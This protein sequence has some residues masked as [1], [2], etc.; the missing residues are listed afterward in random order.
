MDRT[1]VSLSALSPNLA[2]SLDLLADIVRNPAFDPAEVERLRAQQLAQIA[3]EMTQPQGLAL[4]TLPAAL[5]GPSHPYG[6]PFTG[7]G[8]PKAVETVSRDALVAFHDAWLRPDNA[9]IFVVSD[10]P[11]AEVQALVERSFGDWAAPAAPKGTKNLAAATPAPKPRI[12]LV[13]RPQSPQSVILGGLL[14]PYT[15]PQPIEPLIV[16]NDVLGGSFLS[17]I[18]MDLRETKGWSYGVRGGVNRFVGTVPYIITAPVQANQTG[19]S[20]AALQADMREFLTVKGITP[21]ELERTKNN[22][23]RNLAGNFETSDDVLAGMQTIDLLGFPEDYY[24]TIADRYRA[25]TA[26]ELDQ[27]ARRVLD[28]S[29]F[30]WVVV[31]DAAK[32]RPQLDKLGMPIEVVAPR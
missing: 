6:I 26:P 27:A 16:A 4:R 28:P 32:I 30:V 5:Y 31:G 25:M 2:P 10:R 3:D 19:P 7:T 14:L 1:T 20:L 21:E 12:L 18:N 9:K 13:D 8:D 11:L 22:R 24:E 29:K 15:G 17:R 23:I